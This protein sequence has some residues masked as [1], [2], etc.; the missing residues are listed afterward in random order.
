MREI[1][2]IKEYVCGIHWGGCCMCMLML[3]GWMNVFDFAVVLSLTHSLTHS[4]SRV[5]RIFHA[6][7]LV[8]RDLL[9]ETEQKLFHSG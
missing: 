9:L 8:V 2:Y 3:L 7:H 5:A 4:L 6:H 1:I